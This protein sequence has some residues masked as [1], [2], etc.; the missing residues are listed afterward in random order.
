[1]T[2]G[3]TSLN[4]NTLRR[5]IPFNE[6]PDKH[7]QG[8]L[9][10]SQLISL[11]KGKVLFKRDQASKQRYYLLTGE[12]SLCDAEFNNTKLFSNTPETK[13]PIDNHSP[14]KV[15]AIT[16]APAQI[17]CVD[18][19]YL[20]MA[21]TWEQAGEYLVTDLVVEENPT[22]EEETDW[23]SSLLQADLFSQVPPTNIQRLFID[24][25]QLNVEPGQDIIKEGEQ[26]DRFYVINSGSVVVKRSGKTGAEE[27]VTKLKSGDFFGEEALVAETTRNATVTAVSNTKL[28]YLDK[29]KFKSLLQAPV[30]HY[31]DFQEMLSMRKKQP[32][33]KLL[34]VRLPMEYKDGHIEDSVNLP[35]AKMRD[36]IPK[37]NRKICYITTCG[38][39][40]RS[41]LGAYLLS[42]AGFTAYVLSESSS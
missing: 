20:D 19:D 18:N 36:S 28:M 29:E 13:N 40:R 4:I 5:F 11:P 15:S 31:L 21:L 26:G 17:I 1:M 2:N 34:D 24:F 38:G 37:L 32:E 16:T 6:L 9:D 27:I 33:T 7:L 14:H 8:V 23:M 12:V 22:Q 42:Q 39:G 41:E 30:I 35:L 10:K 3:N 25:K